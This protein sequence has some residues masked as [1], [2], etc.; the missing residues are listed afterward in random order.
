M[1]YNI[2]LCSYIFYTVVCR[3]A[4]DIIVDVIIY[5]GKGS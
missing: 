1:L 2:V 5:L 4:V 3:Q